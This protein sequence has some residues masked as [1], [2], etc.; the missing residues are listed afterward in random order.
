MY[1]L[2]N[3]AEEVPHVQRGAE[4]LL[5]E[6]VLAQHAEVGVRAAPHVPVPDQVRRR[7]IGKKI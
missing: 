4:V 3:D 7:E 2:L 5:A 6:H 1:R